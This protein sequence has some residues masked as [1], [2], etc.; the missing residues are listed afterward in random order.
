MIYNSNYSITYF[1]QLKRPGQVGDSGDGGVDG[2]GNLA[3]FMHRKHF[4][5]NSRR[6]SNRSRGLSL[7]GPLTLTTAYLINA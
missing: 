2:V 1:Q 3:Y 7:P 5:V 4:F 6:G